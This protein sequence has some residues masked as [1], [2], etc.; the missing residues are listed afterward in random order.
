M[1]QKIEELKGEVKK[2]KEEFELFKL[3]PASMP[4]RTYAPAVPPRMAK[5]PRV[6]LERV[7]FPRRLASSEIEPFL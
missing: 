3:T 7:P 4:E 2:L 6:P 1:L 5:P